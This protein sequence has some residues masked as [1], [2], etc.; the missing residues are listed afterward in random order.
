LFLSTGGITLDKSRFVFFMALLCSCFP[1]VKTLGSETALFEGGDMSFLLSPDGRRL[2]YGIP[3]Y[4]QD[5]ECI[6]RIMICK[7]DGT[8]QTQIKEVEVCNG[9]VQWLGND[10]L[11]CSEMQSARY[12]VVSPDSN[13]LADIVLPAGC[14]VLYKRLS[15][16]G[17]RVAFVGS[18]Q[19]SEKVRQY[20]LFVVEIKTGQIRCLI[21]KALKSA[22]AWSP[23]SRKIAIGNSPGYVKEYPLVIIDVEP[24]EIS[25]A[26][27]N[28]VGASWSRDGK[29]LAFTTEV[30][31]DVKGGSW[32]YGVPSDGRIGVL[33]I[34]NK[35]LTCVAPSARNI[36]DKE[37]GKWEL[38][39]CIQPVWSPDGNWIAYRKIGYLQA[40]KDAKPT[41]SDET[42][43]VGKQGQEAR[44][45]ADGFG[46]VAWANDS[47]SL[48][49]LKEN[50]IDWVDINTLNSRT[51]ASWEKAKVPEPSP[52]DTVFIKKPGVA[53]EI[54]WID[55]VYGEA[56]AAILSEARREY[57][58]TFGLSLPETITLQAKREPQGSTNLY[59][60]GESYLFLTIKS[61]DDLAPPPQSG[62]FNIYGMCH[63]L[64]HIVMYRK[65]RNLVGLPDGV[66]E[67]WADYS[68]SVVV[69]AV[70]QRL[71]QGIW[72]EHYDVAA[73]EG[74]ARLRNRTDGK[75]WGDLEPI[76]CA[77]KAFYEIEKKYG[78]KNVGSAMNTALSN[79]PSGKELMPLFVKS[80]QELTG[81]PNAGNW[82]PQKMLV[83]ETK[84][85]VKE[86]KVGDNYFTDTKILSDENGILL[87]Y[88][89]GTSE[90]HLSTSGSGHAVLFQKPEGNWLL[91][92]VDVFGSRYG[93]AK[94]PNKKF[95]IYICDEEFNPVYEFSKYYGLFRRGENQWFKLHI[96]PVSVP[97]R[98]YIC[99]SF[100]PIY[101][102]GVY[103]AYDESVEHSHSRSALPYTHVFDVE[104]KYDWMIRAH[105]RKM[106]E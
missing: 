42:W 36:R 74:S 8:G 64:G 105:L 2:S 70:A 73:I 21:D 89:D 18:V 49:I 38:E 24:N 106:P 87:Y 71:G 72:P 97:K 53:V 88:D 90:G 69:D 65:M 26:E 78:R 102:R 34:E 10:R 12:A 68:G 54:T 99:L 35:Q 23:D 57:E 82:I 50:Q 22:P 92:R 39:G 62:V 100:D 52:A 31:K 104:G 59:T 96:D 9:E 5:G 44:K 1:F 46:P 85:E 16:D 58:E 20:G 25:A 28:G 33:D 6:T 43:I 79:Q 14:D 66:G 45:V 80:I 56:F 84:W 37:T 17:C 101:T 13:T 91:D 55:K 63:E 4:S 48:F 61:K 75:N 98:F 30:V 19:S 29:F 76:D 41:E 60:D 47:R 95:T 86:R 32:R 77:A 93:D 11:I 103:V 3:A 7:P 94:P 81:D 27:V 40:S 15:P 67:G 83:S 51:L